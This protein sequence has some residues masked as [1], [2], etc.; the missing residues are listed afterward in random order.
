MDKSLMNRPLGPGYGLGYDRLYAIGKAS[1]NELGFPFRCSFVGQSAGL[2]FWSR[3][4]LFQ[5]LEYL[6]ALTRQ[7]VDLAAPQGRREQLYKFPIP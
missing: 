4:S 6:P 5:L 7:P 2:W 3:I 1:H